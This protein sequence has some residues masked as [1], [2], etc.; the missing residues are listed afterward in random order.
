MLF[1]DNNSSVTAVIKEKKQI[2]VKKSV[3]AIKAIRTAQLSKTAKQAFFVLYTYTNKDNS[4]CWPSIKT[5]SEEYGIARAT[6]RKGI[7][8][9]L[10][11]N[12]LEIHRTKFGENWVSKYHLITAIEVE[13]VREQEIW[14]AQSMED[15]DQLM[16]DDTG[17]N[18]S[19]S[20]QNISGSGKNVPSKDRYKVNNKGDMKSPPPSCSKS[21]KLNCEFSNFKKSVDRAFLGE[22]QKLLEQLRKVELPKLAKST[23]PESE[24]SAKINQLLDNINYLKQSVGVPEYIT[25]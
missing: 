5:A 6:L 25:N 17:K 9:L 8:E 22:K 11:H 4:V 10:E 24:K 18:I 12:W 3:P 14:N 7:N 23:L 15:P 13:E 19:A 2:I 1:E 16:L 21:E 20:D